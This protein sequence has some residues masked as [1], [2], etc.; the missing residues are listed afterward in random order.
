MEEANGQEEEPSV[1]TAHS[2]PEAQGVETL[3]QRPEV[4]G[5]EKEPPVAQAGA[6]WAYWNPELPEASGI[7]DRYVCMKV[8]AEQPSVRVPQRDYPALPSIEEQPAMATSVDSWG[9]GDA[10]GQAPGGEV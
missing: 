8:A 1:A 7:L 9:H 4:S 10:T 5:E 6:T 3:P 2:V